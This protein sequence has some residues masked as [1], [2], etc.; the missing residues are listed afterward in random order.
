MIEKGVEI[1]SLDNDGFTPLY[2][3]VSTYRGEPE[4]LSI[5]R[6]LRDKGADP[7]MKNKSGVSPREF[8][9]IAGEGIDKGY[10]AKEWDLREEL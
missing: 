6:V 7:N 1:D 5:I 3:A 2:L 9:H 8:A 4:L 10:N